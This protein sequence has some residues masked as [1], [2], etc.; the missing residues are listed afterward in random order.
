MSTA[1]TIMVTFPIKNRMFGVDRLAKQLNVLVSTGRI[2][3]WH[4]GRW[5]DWAHGA[6][7]IGFDSPADAQ[8]ADQM[9]RDPTSLVRPTERDEGGEKT[10]NADQSPPIS[11]TYSIAT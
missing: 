2:H 1:D 9:C 8:L 4:P 11:R 6:I 10:V 3:D 5:V 7:E